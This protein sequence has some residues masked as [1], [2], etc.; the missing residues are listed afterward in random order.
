V[1]AVA[2]TLG[3]ARSN[4]VEQ[5][6]RPDRPRRGPY[7]R[8]EDD[9]VIAEI[10]AITDA[11]PTYGYRRVTALLNRARR[12]AGRP[13]L[14]H[15]RVFRLMR[16]ACLLLQPCT[17]GGPFGRMRASS[18]HPPPTSAGPPMGSKFPAGMARWFALPSPS[19]P[20][21]ARS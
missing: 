8:A 7:A 6:Q 21:T 4:L 1:K 16:I 2:D 19:I 5:L 13:R 17:G 9:E 12:G 20:M 14:N 11:R 18:S 10:R 3:V 15:K